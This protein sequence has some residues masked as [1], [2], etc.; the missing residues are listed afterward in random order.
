MV[1]LVNCKLIINLAERQIY[2]FDKKYI[3]L[4]YEILMLSFVP[5]N[6]GAVNA[7]GGCAAGAFINLWITYSI[8]S[9]QS[10]N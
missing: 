5:L 2:E 8:R 1:L 7:I 3:V 10:C 9:I 4:A 6:D